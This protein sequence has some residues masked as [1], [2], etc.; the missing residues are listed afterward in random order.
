[1]IHHT[2]LNY[3]FIQNIKNSLRHLTC[4]KKLIKTHYLI[5]EFNKILIHHHFQDE[6][7]QMQGITHHFELKQMISNEVFISSPL[8]I[9]QL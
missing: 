5:N 3:V 8:H 1:M 4:L 2:A 6:C 9:F 7:K